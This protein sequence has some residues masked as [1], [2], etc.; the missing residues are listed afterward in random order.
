ME[1]I[2][3]DYDFS[4]M[5]ELA[6]MFDKFAILDK[7]AM[8]NT[9]K[10]VHAAAQYVQNVWSNYLAGGE[11]EGIDPLEHPISPKNANLRIENKG[12]F[13]EDIVSSSKKVVEI[14]TGSDPVYYDMK[15]THPYGLKSRMSSKGVPYLIIPFRWGTPNDKGTKRRWNNVIPQA[16]YDTVVK[17]LQLSRTNALKNYYQNNA[18][19]QSIQRAGYDWAKFGRLK[20]V[21]AWND[22]SEGMVRMKDTR[23]ST[24]FTFRIIS[25]KSP[26]G[27]WLYWKDG[28]DAV[29]MIGAL[30]NTVQERVANIIETGIRSD[31]GL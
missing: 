13:S 29:D 12:P 23:G 8:P 26:M 18:K 17:D 30:K 21:D 6:Q 14:Q 5:G 20:K 15:R 16:E 27:S 7:N 4:Q 11:L 9:S 3:L 10:S 2:K 31:L 28:K 19:G 22:R 25:A 1:S 24:Y